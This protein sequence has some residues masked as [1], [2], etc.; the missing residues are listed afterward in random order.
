MEKACEIYNL[1]QL[2]RKEQEEEESFHFLIAP[3]KRC[4]CA[5]AALVWLAE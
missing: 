2:S 4:S 1:L 3:N 5:L